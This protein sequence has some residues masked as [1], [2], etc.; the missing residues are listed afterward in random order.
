MRVTRRKEQEKCSAPVRVYSYGARVPKEHLGTA[1]DI[2]FK[3]HQYRNK[4]T[5]IIHEADAARRNVYTELSPE[6]VTVNT[7]IEALNTRISAVYEAHAVVMSERRRRVTDPVKKAEIQELKAQR[8]VLFKE[9]GK[10]KKAIRGMPAAKKLFTAAMEAR[11]RQEKAARA[12]SGVYHGTYVSSEEAI[13]VAE[14]KSAGKWKDNWR[15]RMGRPL[16]DTDF[17]PRFKRF[18]GEGG[19]VVQIGRAGGATFKEITTGKCQYLYLREPQGLIWQGGIRVGSDEHRKPVW[20]PFSIKLHRGIPDDCKVTW[21]KLL[22]FRVGTHTK[23]ELQ[24]TL[25]REAGFDDLRRELEK[26][27]IAMDVGWR[28]LPQG[29]RVAYWVDNK[30]KQGEILIPQERLERLRKIDDLKAIRDKNFNA[31]KAEL[32]TWVGGAQGLPEWF[33]GALTHLHL[34]NAQARM[35][36]FLLNWRNQRFQGDQDIYIK[37]EAWRKQDKHLLDWQEHQRRGEKKW[38]DYFYR[39][40]AAGLSRSYRQVVI[41]D[42]DL[43]VFSV[44]PDMLKDDEDIEELIRYYKNTAGVSVLRRFIEEKMTVTTKAPAEFTTQQCHQCLH[45]EEFDAKGLVHTCIRCGAT[46]DQDYNA[47]MNLLRLSSGGVQAGPQGALAPSGETQ[48][49]AGS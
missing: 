8:A 39:N 37:M 6:L 30:G 21:A 25:K 19:I 11:G 45:T 32:Q 41:E 10:L 34:W 18:D 7:R 22:A 42:F 15:P 16:R 49:A 9:A 17:L 29:L 31:A 26:G 40:V 2:L 44:E 46:W 47:C 12:A 43:R 1:F 20:L 5:E 35:A 28:K 36:R 14:K 13:A 33:T 27:V 23:W 3:A 24:L 48:V 4:L 38:R